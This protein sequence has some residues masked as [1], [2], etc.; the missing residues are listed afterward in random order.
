MCGAYH[1]LAKEFKSL[2]RTHCLRTSLDILEHNM[3]L[4][5]HLLGLHGHHIQ[6]GPVGREKGIEREP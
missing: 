3:S 1:L 2:K 6:N 4:S 5:A